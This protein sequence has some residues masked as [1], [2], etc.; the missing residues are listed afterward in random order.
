M[1]SIA[2]T[3]LDIQQIN[4]N[5]SG[6]GAWIGGFKQIYLISLFGLSLFKVNSIAVTK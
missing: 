5:Q 2:Q 6:D 4:K 3:P 1:V